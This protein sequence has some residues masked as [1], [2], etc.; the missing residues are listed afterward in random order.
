MASPTRRRLVATVAVVSAVAFG[1]GWMLGHGAGTRPRHAGAAVATALPPGLTGSTVPTVDA[2]LLGA[3]TTTAPAWASVDV[4]VD[5]RAAAL[6]IRVVGVRSGRVIELDTATG[7][8]AQ[9]VTDSRYRT[10]PHVDAGADWFLVRRPDM[11]ISQLFRGRDQPVPVATG[12]P[13]ELLA[14]IGTDR[15]WRVFFSADRRVP[16]RVVE[17]DAEVQET[18]VAFD[19]DGSGRVVAADP[20][21]G[22]IVVAPGGA[23]HA[24]TGGSQRI[25]VG[26]IVAIGDRRALVTEC[27]DNLT[28]CGLVVL[29]RASGTT[30]PLEPVLP[31]GAAGTQIYDSG[32]SYGQPSL[33]TDVS[34]DGRYAPL[35]IN[36]A[37]LRFGV[38]DLD[39]G[40]FSPLGISPQSGLWWAPDSRSVMYVFNEH[41]MLYDFDTRRAF[42]VVPGLQVTAFAVRP[43]A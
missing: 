41:L 6:A 25:T 18:G 13:E 5:P 16:I 30:V 42:D 24:G 40:V 34:P 38:I 37:R 17:V 39:S 2:G 29:D 9:L 20:A 31:A 35:V 21:G 1:L 14:E 32:A 7:K 4:N 26:V 10:T 12:Y 22:V 36:G 43:A 23:Y 11:A 27:S 19:V 33:L 8:L 15:F 28:T 3:T